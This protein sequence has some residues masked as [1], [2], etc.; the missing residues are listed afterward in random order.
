MPKR[1]ADE[2]IV[3]GICLICLCGLIP[4]V[5]LRISMGD[6]LVAAIDAF[7]ALCCVA[8]II[9]IRR[10][11][12]ITY[13][14]PAIAILALAGMSANITMLGSQDIYFLYPV[15]V[16]AFF[17]MAPLQALLAG[18]LASCLV[19][20]YVH[21]QLST[22]ETLKF[23]FSILGTAL[24]AFTFAWQR[25]RQNDLLEQQSRLDPLTGAG[26]RRALHEQIEA[27]ITVHERDKQ[28]M[29]L[30]ILDLDDF[31]EINDKHGHLTGD[32]VLKQLTKIITERIRITDHLYRYGGDEFMILANHSDAETT[33]VLAEDIRSLINQD[34]TLAE[35]PI[36]V[37]I[38]ISEYRLNEAAD[39]WLYRADSAMYSVK[40]N[41]KNAVYTDAPLLSN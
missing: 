20:V 35:A 1:S 5:I 9:H 7:G 3:L 18:C 33:R 16:L 37:S 4:F 28:P 31:K 22:F 34:K 40:R 32:K 41:G 30:I 26:N 39:D 17:L 25:N 8:G 24:L 14:A 19:A 36:G 21:P 10:S 23:L 11:G 13:I 12:S 29:S 6:W 2:T 27:L 15:V 38:G